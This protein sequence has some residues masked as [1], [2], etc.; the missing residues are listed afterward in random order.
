[1]QK[2]LT[3]VAGWAALSERSPAAA[4]TSVIDLTDGNP[5]A[6][7]SR[8]WHL[9]NGGVVQSASAVH[10]TA[11]GPAGDPVTLL[12][13]KPQI[14]LLRPFS[15]PRSMPVL[16]DLPLDSANAIG[17]DPRLAPAGGGQSWLVGYAWLPAGP[18]S[19][20]VHAS[21]LFGPP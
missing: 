13:Q 10:G 19:P 8:C 12:L 17:S 21:P 3:S 1:M 16:L 14:R 11:G 7:E 9:V 6:P 18:V 20:G 15:A 4:P 5:N 2:T